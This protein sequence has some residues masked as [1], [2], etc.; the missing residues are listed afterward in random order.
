MPTDAMNELTFAGWL[1]EFTA[2]RA[3]RREDAGE[4]V[5]IASAA[6]EERQ[7]DAEG[8]VRRCDLR[9][10]S[11]SGRKLASGE[12]KRPEVPE[13]RDPR[14]E[15]LRFDARR[16]AVARGLPYY[17][18]CNIADVVLYQVANNPTE[19]DLEVGAFNLA[20]ITRSG[21]AEAYRAQIDKQWSEF[22]DALEVKLTA[23]GRTRPTVTTED[24]I[25]IRDAIYAVANEVLPRILRRV[26]ADPSLAEELRQESARSFNFP[27]ALQEKFPDK[28]REELIQMLRFGTFVVTQ[29][30]ILYRVLEDAGPRRSDPYRLDQLDVPRASTDPQAI[31]TVLDQAFSLAIRRSKDYET[32]FSPQNFVPLV[33][34]DPEGAQETAE[35]QIGEVWHQLLTTVKNVSWLSISQNIVGLLYEVIV[36]ERFRHQLGQFYTPEDVVDLLTGFAIRAPGELVLDPATGGGSF[37]R[38][39]YHRK[40][41]LG[42]NHASALA[43]IWGCEITAF[44]AEL[45]TVTLVTSDTHEPA[46][47]PRVLL[48]DFFELR[49]G[50]ETELE[51]PGE[52]GR[53]K[54]PTEFDA[55]IGNPPYI[56]YRRI[57]NQPKILNA[58][59]TARDDITMPKFTG[60]SDA[61]L[62]FIV[63]A[64]QF[65]KNG[66]RL[67]FVVS[68]A[69][70]FADYGIP[71]IQFIGHHFRIRAIV[72]STV[73]RWFAD[74]DTNTV[75]LLLERETDAEARS[76]NSIRFVRLRRPLAQLIP[77]PSSPDR[78]GRIEELVA[79]LLEASATEDDPRMQ[80]NL[81]VQGTDGGLQIEAGNDDDEEG[82]L[83]EDDE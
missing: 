32:A 25:A 5:L 48:R 57:T 53:L 14:N 37:L 34:T 40:R 47:Y 68:S 7:V 28:F 4:P 66:G 16:K 23:I 39:A 74:A 42:E 73:E 52:L 13:G 63:H 60:K 72:D 43:T 26:R 10:N 15:K 19:D 1:A 71:L 8:S 51:I 77:D 17:F 76:S 22:L 33:F 24:V 83:E 59:A 81:V 58:L 62:W 2:T 50:L 78:R 56:S 30:L 67:S 80:V 11:S 44:A 38:S 41:A 31:K 69:I 70:L 82:L 55:V 61:Y 49:P 64:T 27:A 79:Q 45:S 36:E 18:T 54:I 75:L 21:Q 46:A 9:F 29:K 12:L 65:L 35:C 6:I 20:P 3:K